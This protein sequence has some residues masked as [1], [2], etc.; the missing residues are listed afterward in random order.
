MPDVS[1]CKN[2][3]ENHVIYLKMFLASEMTASI[4]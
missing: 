3:M 2:G 4:F 1:T